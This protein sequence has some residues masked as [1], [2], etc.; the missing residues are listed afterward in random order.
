MADPLVGPPLIE[1][2]LQAVTTL[3]H[4]SDAKQKESASQWLQQLQKSVH[5][6]KVSER[7]SVFPLGQ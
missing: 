4:D 5:A 6:W 7:T 3:Y 2:V 1:T